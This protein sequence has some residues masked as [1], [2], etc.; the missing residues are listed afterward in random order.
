[1]ELLQLFWEDQN[2]LIF[3]FKKI[4]EEK[5]KLI[6]ENVKSINI[7]YE[8]SKKEER[9][10][11]IIQEPFLI[12]IKNIYF[13]ADIISFSIQLGGLSDLNKLQINVIRLTIFYYSGDREDIFLNKTFQ[14]SE[15][16]YND[17]EL[18][19]I[20][21]E[22]LI[23]ETKT[24]YSLKKRSLNRINPQKSQKQKIVKTKNIKTEIVGKKGSLQKSTRKNITISLNY[25][26]FEKWL[27]LK[28]DK[29]WETTFHIVREGYEK[30][31]QLERDVKRLNSTIRKIALKNSNGPSAPIYLQAPQN[32]M[33]YP[34]YLNP[35]PNQQS[36]SRN[37]DKFSLT[38]GNA[39]K[40]LRSDKDP[41]ILSGQIQVMKEMKE[42]F[43]K[44]ND[45][46]ELLSKV[47]EEEL[48][49][50]RAKT[51][52]LSFLEFKEKSLIN[53]KEILIKKLKE[54][55]CKD[56][57]KNYNLEELKEKVKLL[58]SKK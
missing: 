15:I 39:L 5:Q 12:S 38:D 2:R 29:S 6:Q 42:K 16:S 11:Y 4:D 34:A 43:N 33:G 1:M 30:V 58:I 46:R 49:K 23:F 57:L 27:E 17:G 44:I 21:E 48:N 36:P 9:A 47:P 18:I 3:K 24:K 54:L 40:V 45:V 41:K 19:E 28:E 50:K 7:K 31:K 37:N 26:E 10:P 32:M 56:K 55:G 53:E 51:D 35:P 14:L 25:S 8:L 22:E 13:S 52:H 20:T